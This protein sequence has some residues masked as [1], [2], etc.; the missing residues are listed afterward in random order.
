[1]QWIF[2][3]PRRSLALMS[4]ACVAMLAFGLYLQ[5]AVGLDPCPM[6]I[7]QRYALVGVAITT[8]LASLRPQK[9]WQKIWA[10]LAL[11]LAGFGAFTAARQSWLQW[12]PPRLGRLLGRRLDIFRRQHCQLVFPLV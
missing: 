2:S 8:G 5:H 10:A 6:C 12:N 3:A 11:L 9:T 1:M 7:V 4:A